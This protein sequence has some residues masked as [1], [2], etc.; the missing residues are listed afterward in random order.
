MALSTWLI[1][2]QPRS[3]LFSVS[4]TPPLNISSG[5][6]TGNSS[7]ITALTHFKKSNQLLI[8]SE[9]SLVTYDLLKQAIVDTLLSKKKSQG[10]SSPSVLDLSHD[11][12]YSIEGES[13]RISLRSMKTQQLVAVYEGHQY[14]VQHLKFALATYTFVS[15]AHSECMLWSPTEQI[16]TQVGDLVAE[17]SQ[18]EKILDLASS[19]NIAHVTLKEIGDDKTF[20]IAASTDQ[21]VNVFYAKVA[22][23]A[24]ASSVTKSKVAK[25]E[26]VITLG[27]HEQMISAS[28]VNE[29]NLTVVH[30]SMFSMKRSQVK[31]LDD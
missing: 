5:N 25:K 16:K 20:M 18:P 24:K 7:K 30:G 23:S 17:V 12:Q 19:D 15:T 27:V 1:A 31:L 8:A 29:T 21:A 4:P 14:P 13:Q 26:C 6:V 3:R 2:Q 11:D 22:K 28:L 10:I 9:E